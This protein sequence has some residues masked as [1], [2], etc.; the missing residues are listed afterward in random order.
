MRKIIKDNLKHPLISGSLIIFS[1]SIFTNLFNVIFNLFMSRNLSV[2]DYGTLASLISLILLPAMGVSAFVPLIIS[3][4]GSY[5][6]KG[7]LGKVRGLFISLVRLCGVMGIFLFLIFLLFSKQIG[8]FFNI[9]NSSLIVLAGVGVLINYVGTINIA[10]LQAKLAF[11]FLTL[12]NLLSSFIKVAFGVGLVYLGFSI[13]GAVWALLLSFSL[14]YFFTFIPLR[15]LFDR[16]IEHVQISSRELIK[17]GVPSAVTQFA[18]LSFIMTDIILVKHFFD[19]KTAGLY[20]GLSLVGRVV[21]FFS[22]PINT[23]MFPLIVQKYA[24]KENYHNTFKLSLFLVCL[25][26]ACLVVFYFIFPKFALTFFLKNADYLSVAPLLALFGIFIGVYSIL[27]L[28][29]NF[30]LSIKKT[31]IYIPIGIGAF[32]QAILIWFFHDSFLQIIMVSL[33][34]TSLLLIL[35]LLYYWKL[36]EDQKAK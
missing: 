30:F 18:L 12:I 4:G 9:N 17:Y 24:K 14:P 20:A 21:F 32:L 19:P 26:S 35:F 2:P 15:F 27:S 1:G 22:A 36:H 13:G 33:V 28:L 16:N 29:T 23:V 5:F 11:K 3:F 34:I 10:L 8:S 25:A 7:E 31:K 6:V